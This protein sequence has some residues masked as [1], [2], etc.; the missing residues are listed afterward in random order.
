MARECFNE[1]NLMYDNKD[2]VVW[3]FLC[4]L[5]PTHVRFFKYELA[6]DSWKNVDI[7]RSFT[8][9]DLSTNGKELLQSTIS[10]NPVR[11]CHRC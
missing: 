5:S 6:V 8:A 7:Y 1:R 3:Q 2:G 9:S 4:N 10:H 11:L